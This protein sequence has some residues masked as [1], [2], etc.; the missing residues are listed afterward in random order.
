MRSKSLLVALLFLVTLFPLQA[1]QTTD[2]DQV[3][4]TRYTGGSKAFLELIYRNITYPA[5]ARNSCG[6]GNLHVEITV[7][8]SGQLRKLDFLND[9]GYG[10]ND[11][12]ASILLATKG[13]WLPGEEEVTVSLSIAFQLFETPKVEGDVTVIAHT[14]STSQTDSGCDSNEELIAKLGKAIEKDKAKKVEKLVR[15]LTRRGCFTAEFLALK[16]AAN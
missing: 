5:A 12:V 9:F 15:E 4:D 11:E 14:G 2:L 16:E 8:K 1:Q 13:Q 7:S 3:L 6:I 10:V